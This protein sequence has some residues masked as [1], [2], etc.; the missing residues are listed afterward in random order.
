VIFCGYW[1]ELGIWISRKA[2]SPCNPTSDVKRSDMG[3]PVC[4]V[5]RGGDI[6]RILG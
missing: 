2:G 4:A 6:L 1:D 5:E 3:H